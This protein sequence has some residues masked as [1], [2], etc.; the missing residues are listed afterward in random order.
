[1]VTQYVTYSPFTFLRIV[2]SAHPD[3]KFAS[4][5]V[6]AMIPYFNFHFFPHLLIFLQFRDTSYVLNLSTKAILQKW[7]N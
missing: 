5:M 4:L 7:H 6:L 3:K 1:M 2:T